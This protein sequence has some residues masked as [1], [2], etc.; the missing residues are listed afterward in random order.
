MDFSLI[1]Y[2]LLPKYGKESIVL[3]SNFRNGD[4]SWIY[5]KITNYTKNTN[6]KSRVSIDIFGS[7]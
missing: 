7:L 1:F 2:F 5:T 3:G 6:T 4:F